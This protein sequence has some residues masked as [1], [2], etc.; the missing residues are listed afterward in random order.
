MELEVNTLNVQDI[1][2]LIT[3]H[4]FTFLQARWAS[5]EDSS[6]SGPGTQ[7]IQQLAPPHAHLTRTPVINK[8]LLIMTLKF[9]IT[10]QSYN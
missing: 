4:S 3:S 7:A 9:I 1:L 8:R 10:P 5:E 2:S 6:G